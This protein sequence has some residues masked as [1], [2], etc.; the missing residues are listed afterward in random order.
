MKFRPIQSIAPTLTLFFLAGCLSTI[1]AAPKE[2]V[3]I[4]VN[5]IVGPVTYAGSGFLEGA[6]SM[7]EP[8]DEL[9]LPLKVHRVRGREKYLMT[10]YRKCLQLG[11]PMEVIGTDKQ[12]WED[13]QLDGTK[14]AYQKIEQHFEDLVNRMLDLGLKGLDYS[15]FLD[16]DSPWIN[17]VAETDAYFLEAYR[18]AYIAIKK[19]DPEA[20]IAG[21]GCHWAPITP[22]W[23][24]HKGDYSWF[25]RRFI[26]YSIENNCVPDIISWH[27][28]SLDG[29]GITRDAKAIRDYLK[30]K[31]LPDLPLEQDD[32][33][34]KDSVF[35]PGIFASYL[36]NIERSRIKYTVKCCWNRDCSGNSLQGL[37]TKGDHQ[38]RSLWWMYKAYGELTGN[39][40]EVT[41]SETADAIAAVDTNPMII[42]AVIGRFKNRGEPVQIRFKGLGAQMMS[43]RIVAE[44]IKNTED[45]P[46]GHT[47]QTI[48][49][50][51]P[52]KNGILDVVLEDLNPF[53]AYTITITIP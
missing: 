46:L 33:G 43:A 11:I 48:S 21:P 31:G 53:D 15:V 52:V 6:F 45:L 26:D 25:L 36:A 50:T 4:D 22:W 5:R 3:Q 47:E 1:C 10:V 35:R 17:W 27:D 38:P 16:A 49:E 32:M 13:L 2:C 23:K 28:Y 12:F 7:D 51:R 20:K 29:L 24:E 14:D 37:L 34:G 8:D 44:R 41:E 39:V 42:R 19:T 40:L 18:C 9:F 30:K